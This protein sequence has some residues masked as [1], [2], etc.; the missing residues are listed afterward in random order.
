MAVFANDPM[1]E[2]ICTPGH[3]VGIDADGRCSVC[4]ERLAP[5][6]LLRVGVL[7]MALSILITLAIVAVAIWWACG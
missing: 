4:N 7:L 3:H 2:P 6:D 1:K 5:R